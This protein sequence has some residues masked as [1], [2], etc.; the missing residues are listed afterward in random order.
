MAIG[1]GGARSEGVGK[2]G[3]GVEGFV[4]GEIRRKRP[5]TIFLAGNL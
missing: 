1:L 5:V 2:G 4:E 3:A